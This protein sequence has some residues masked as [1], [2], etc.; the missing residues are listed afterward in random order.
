[1]TKKKGV[2]DDFGA[3]QY[4]KI[5]R[6]PYRSSRFVILYVHQG[7]AGRWGFLPFHSFLLHGVRKLL[8]KSHSV[9]DIVTAP[10]P[11]PVFIF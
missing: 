8:A 5:S 6:L 7:S 11:N 2:T 1:M 3:S 4:S 9:R 10:A